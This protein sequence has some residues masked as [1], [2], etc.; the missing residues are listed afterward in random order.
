MRKRKS[1]IVLI[2]LLAIAAC[3][4]FGIQY[5]SNRVPSPEQPVAPPVADTTKTLGDSRAVQP[6]K[7]VA[8]QVKSQMGGGGGESGKPTAMPMRTDMGSEKGPGAPSSG[9]MV[10]DNDPRITPPQNTKPKPNPSSTSS[11]WYNPETANG[12]KD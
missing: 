7:S 5:V 2:T 10:V 8:E 4:A 3:G 12:A 1:P 11:Q 9:S 6:V